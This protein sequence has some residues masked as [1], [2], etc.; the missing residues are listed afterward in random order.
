MAGLVEKAGTGIQ[1]MKDAMLKA[2][3]KEPKIEPSKNFFMLTFYGHKKEEL[4]NA[5]SIIT[6][7]E[8]EGMLPRKENE[9]LK[10][11]LQSSSQN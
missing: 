6:K 1:R 9:E 11:Y 3:L 7:I 10:N 5:K 8:G 2:G 4:S